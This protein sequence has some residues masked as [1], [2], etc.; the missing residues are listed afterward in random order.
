MEHGQSTLDELRSCIEIDGRPSWFRGVALTT[1]DGPSQVLV[2][3]VVV[4]P[5]PEHWKMR[6]WKYESCVFVEGEMSSSK[7]CEALA[8]EHPQTLEIGGAALTFQPSPSNFSWLHRP[9]M[10][11]YDEPKMSFPSRVYSLRLANAERMNAPSNFLVGQGDVR[12]YAVFSIAFDSFFHGESPAT[13]SQNPLMGELS[14]R[15]VD[16]R[17]RIVGVSRTS[18]RLEIQVAGTSLESAIIEFSSPTHCAMKRAVEASVVSFDLPL[19]E[20]PRDSWIWLKADSD[21]LDYRSLQSWGG[22]V[23][24]DVILVTE[25]E[26]NAQLDRRALQIDSALWLKERAVTS[27]RKALSLYVGEEIRDFVLFAGHAIE[28]ACKALLAEQNLAFLAPDG[29][30]RSAVALWTS[31]SDM[32]T[33][34]NGTPTVGA[35]A[36]FERLVILHPAMNELRPGVVELLQQRN[37]EVHLGLIDATL[38][39]RVFAAFLKSMNLLL[40]IADSELNEFWRPHGDLVRTILDESAKQVQQ[41]VQL[42]VSAAKEQFKVIESLPVEQRDAL[43]KVIAGQRPEVEIDEAEVECPACRSTAIATGAN[44]LEVGEVTVG[45]EGSIDGV[46]TWLRFTPLS[47]KCPFCGLRLEN[48]AELSAAGIPGSW[49]NENEEIKQAFLEVDPSVEEYLD[50]VDYGNGDSDDDGDWQ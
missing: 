47:L 37:G 7:L 1:A 20:I 36:A 39:R 2:A 44:E 46:E 32:E 21:W 11:P 8:S 29:N 22:F 13:G 18:D 25:D 30:F 4:G 19:G 6:V 45:R 17:A 28:I 9:S 34:P 31:R 41:S 14:I 40:D 24:P 5:R 26:G 23:S 10:A 48:R 3:R 38:Q 12:S 33:L 43:V 50:S 15:I 16:E 49:V 35:R 27:S 42:K